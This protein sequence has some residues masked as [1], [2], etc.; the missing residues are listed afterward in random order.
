MAVT[1]TYRLHTARMGRTDA[2]NS[3]FKYNTLLGRYP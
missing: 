1:N 3:I 2:G